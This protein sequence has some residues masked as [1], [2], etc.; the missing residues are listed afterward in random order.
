MSNHAVK[1]KMPQSW[2]H[3][4]VW[5]AFGILFFVFAVAFPLL[6]AHPWTKD[7]KISW[8]TVT[9]QVLETR[10]VVVGQIE[11]QYQPGEIDYQ[12]EAHVIFER[13][14]VQ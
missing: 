4:K 3:P 7:Y 14:G 13:N 5:N 8:P 1:P 2:K 12:A 10:I 9:G 6:I 11:H